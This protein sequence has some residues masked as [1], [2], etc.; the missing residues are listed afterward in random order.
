MRGLQQGILQ[1]MQQLFLDKCATVETCTRRGATVVLQIKKSV[2][3]LPILALMGCLWSFI[4]LDKL[5]LSSS[6]M[7]MLSLLFW[8]LLIEPCD[9]HSFCDR[10][11][12]LTA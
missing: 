7:M 10:L 5:I 11:V 3:L 2:C 4:A 12:S 6:K 9:S 1:P 8:L